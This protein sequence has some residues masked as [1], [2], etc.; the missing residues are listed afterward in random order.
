MIHGSFIRVFTS[1]ILLGLVF[2]PHTNASPVIEA[3][4][5]LNTHTALSARCMSALG[6]YFPNE[7]VWSYNYLSIYDWT[8]SDWLRLDELHQRRFYTP[9]DFLNND[10]PYW[11]DIF[12]D[13]IEE[14]QELFLRVVSDFA[15]QEIASILPKK[16]G[17]HA[18]LAEQCAAREMYQYAAYLS[19]CFDATQR[20]TKLQE[21]VTKPP[22]PVD[23][24]LNL[25]E[26]NFQKL[27]E[28]EA[29]KALRAA[30]KHHMEKIYLHASW[31]ASHCHE[32]GLVLRPGVTT[33]A[34]T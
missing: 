31:V 12:D 32:H 29:D 9:A 15:C 25:F 34:Y 14:R 11:R 27:D 19:A 10:F 30:A 20:L 24:A 21:I 33:Q 3:C 18:E 16:Y 17:M 22:N 4:L 26:V 6:E 5:P 2:V 7:P 23:R 8:G 1:F 13:Q 28:N